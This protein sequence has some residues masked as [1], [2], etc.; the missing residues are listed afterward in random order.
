M[1]PEY[2]PCIDD[3][4]CLTRRTVGTPILSVNIHGQK[5]D[6]KELGG[7]RDERKR[8]KLYS[9]FPTFGNSLKYNTI[10]CVLYTVSLCSY[11]QLCF[12]D[13]LKNN[14]KGKNKFIDSI[15]LFHEIADNDELQDVTILILLTFM[16]QFKENLYQNALNESECEI[17]KDFRVSDGFIDRASEIMHYFVNYGYGKSVDVDVKLPKDTAYLI[18]EYVN[19]GR[20]CIDAYYEECL[21]FIKI[22][23]AKLSEDKNQSVSIYAVNTLN[24]KEI[25]NIVRRIESKISVLRMC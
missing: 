4:L 21:S 10:D 24:T 12:E 5:Y 8:W 11:N 13:S 9:Q 7:H 17:F 3:I 16:D 25:E 23:F 1:N 20:F 19:I 18:G 22:Y 2:Q 14:G 15:E 6:F